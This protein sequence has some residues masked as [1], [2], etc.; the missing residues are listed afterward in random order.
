M[1]PGEPGS[2]ACCS[3]PPYFYRWYE[4]APG[5]GGNTSEYICGYVAINSVGCP[6][7][8]QCAEAAVEFC[9]GIG[10]NSRCE[11]ND[12]DG[13]Y[14]IS[15]M[16][17]QLGTDCKDTPGTGHLIHPGRDEDFDTPYDDNCDG[18]KNCQD[19]SCRTNPNSNCDAQCDEDGDGFYSLDC[20]GP[21]CQDDPEQE[22]NAVN[23]HPGQDQENSAAL[24]HDG[25]NNNCDSSIDCLD[26]DCRT[27]TEYCPECLTP[28]ICGPPANDD[29]EDCDD[30]INCD[31]VDSCSNDPWCTGG[32]TLEPN[33]MTQHCE[34]EYLVTL[35]Y[36]CNASGCTYLGYTVEFIGMVCPVS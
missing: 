1:S 29:D 28:E 9:P 33:N 8:G 4:Y 14:G 5:C 25:V 27:P 30:H 23:I 18:L 19:P 32:V 21:D 17:C 31:D 26:S 11:D 22:P 13:F 20:G 7:G 3:Q 24:C 6:A 34:G 2:N 36:L 10:P 15:L 12:G 35:Y 16:S